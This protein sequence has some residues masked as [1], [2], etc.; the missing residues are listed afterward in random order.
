[1]Q[2]YLLLASELSRKPY[3]KSELCQLTGRSPKQVD[4]YIKTLERLFEME[5]DF[6]G[7]YFIIR[8]EPMAA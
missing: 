5:E 7:R 3:S 6:Q 2:M 4:R 8:D 1:M